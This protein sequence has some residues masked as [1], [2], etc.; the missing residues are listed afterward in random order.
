MLT[1]SLVAVS[2]DPRVE[3]L[4]AQ[5]PG[6]ADRALLVIHGGPDWDHT[7]LRDPLR[8]LAGRFR[9]VLPDLRGC[10]RSTRGL[11]SGCYTPDAAVADLL[12]L[13]DRLGLANVDLLGFSYGGL[14]AQRLAVT[15]PARVRRLIIASSSVGLVPAGAFGGWAE[16]DQRVAA[17]AAVWAGSGLSGPALTRAAA[18][19]GAPANVWQAGKLPGYL[20]RL[21]AVHFGG[22]WMAPWRAGTLQPAHLPGAV[23]RL[24]L[25]G[26]PVLLLHG[27]HDMTTPAA[28][29][30]R[31]AVRIPGATAVILG[32]AGH[33]AHVDQ[34]RDWLAAVSRFLEPAG[35]Q[36][37]LAVTP[38]LG[39]RR[40]RASDAA[41]LPDIAE[42]AWFA[43]QAGGAT[44]SPWAIVR[45]DCGAV[46][47]YCGL[48]LRPAKGITLGYAITAGQRGQGFA[49][50][51][52]DALLAWAER[53]GLGVYASIRPPNPASERVLQKIGMRLTASY[54][55][56]D[57]VRNVYRRPRPG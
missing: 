14:L 56:G 38:R 36:E 18:V 45:H 46:A 6:P 27:E 33:M 16:R 8:E 4:V 23:Q 9:L 21:S 19:A 20:D 35:G 53:R 25:L 47:G 1:E 43:P 15:A 40:L 10:G 42:P 31:A 57:G 44:L 32:D 26:V 50:E 51:A 52:A 11:P 37:W 41:A 28:L 12:A 55:D 7:Y 39:L 5:S 54:T 3:L 22:E 24:G 13:L 34:P 30:T 2:A 29:I 48:L 49:A 17:E